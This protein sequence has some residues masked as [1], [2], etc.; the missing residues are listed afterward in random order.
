M[1]GQKSQTFLSCFTEASPWCD[2]TLTY[3]CKILSTISVGQVRCTGRCT[4]KI[5][6][7]PRPI[8]TLL[9][10]EMLE[11]TKGKVGTVSHLY[12]IIYVFLWGKDNTQ[13]IIDYS[14]VKSTK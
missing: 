12:P 7:K 9:I 10:G 1:M 8:I 5:T 4:W 14:Q 6:E 3:K 11:H 13:K 2:I